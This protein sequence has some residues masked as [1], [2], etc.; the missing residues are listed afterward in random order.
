MKTILWILGPTSWWH[1]LDCISS[2]APAVHCRSNRKNGSSLL[3]V[4]H[5]NGY[6]FLNL[7]KMNLHGW[8]DKSHVTSICH[9][10]SEMSWHKISIIKHLRLISWVQ[11]TINLSPKSKL[12]DIKYWKLYHRKQHPLAEAADSCQRFLCQAPQASISSPSFLNG[13]RRP[14][15]NE[16]SQAGKTLHVNHILYVYSSHPGRELVAR[17]FPPRRLCDNELVY[18]MQPGPTLVSTENH[19]W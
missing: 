13:K 9:K 3:S 18:V 12:Q 11:T 8:Y 2:I 7:Y 14:S 10:T 16:W 1:F 6:G 17:H 19:T 4:D 5:G 15:I